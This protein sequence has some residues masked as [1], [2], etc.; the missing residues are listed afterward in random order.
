MDL[1][2]ISVFATPERIFHRASSLEASQFTLMFYMVN[3]MN[4]YR[5]NAEPTPLTA[6]GST[7]SPRGKGSL[8]NTV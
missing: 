6:G 4:W 2:S 8:I 5:H 1:Q 3:D 7:K